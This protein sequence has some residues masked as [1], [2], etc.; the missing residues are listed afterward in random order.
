MFVQC[1]VWDSDTTSKIEGF[2][3]EILKDAHENDYLS[4]FLKE[5]I[6]TDLYKEEFDR[7][8]KKWNIKS[9]LSNEAE[10]ISVGKI[11]SNKSRE[12]PQ[13]IILIHPIIFS[14]DDWVDRINSL[15]LNVY[16]VGLLPVELQI[17]NEYYCN[18]PINHVADIFFAFFFETYY[19][20]LRVDYK[21]YSNGQPPISP[22]NIT[23]A[24]KRKLK[25]LQLKHQDDLKFD[26][27][28]IKAYDALFTFL[29]LSVEA[30]RYLFEFS[31]YGI[32]EIPMR[33]FI[34]QLHDQVINV[35]KNDP[36]STLFLKEVMID[37][38]G[39]SFL[40][41]IENPYEIKVS[42]DP[43]GLFPD[44]VDTHNRIVAFVDVLGF[45]NMIRR[46]DLEK[47]INLLKDLKE[48]L[49][50]A[51]LKMK[52]MFRTSSG[53]FECKL[54]SDC[55]CLSVP[56]YDT[57]TDFSYQFATVM[58]GIKTYQMLMLMKGYI[59]RGGIAIGSYYSNDNMI[60]S[61]AL[62]EAASFEKNGSTCGKSLPIKFPR[63]LVAPEILEKL[64]GTRIHILMEAYFKDG[65]VSDLDG[66]V[67]VN[68]F[69]NGDISRF[70]YSNIYDGFQSAEDEIA[71]TLKTIVKSSL[72]LIGSLL[73]PASSEIS[74]N[75]LI[76]E[77]NS[78]IL[79]YENESAVVSKYI[80]VS[81]F[82]DWLK[83]E[84]DPNRFKYYKVDF[85][86]IVDSW[87]AG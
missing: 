65:L 62:V 33:K 70:V 13:H 56:Y 6:I 67:F 59:L 51:V 75:V 47:D 85:K 50:G 78:K 43:K 3:V 41:I 83:K 48:S 73:T 52:A 9:V 44:V 53:N 22:R 7:I 87:N 27:L 31:E 86:E 11:C 15:L 49:D 55:F 36:Y 29:N 4:P 64:K 23:D 80:W 38:L 10:Y 12:D 19:A 69:F 42:E 25:R 34:T 17:A 32:F 26:Y 84:N 82:L 76:T 77:V 81:E 61:G 14:E 74:M 54:F 60:F 58:L 30:T 63:I 71:T 37:I 66:E 40:K 68:P 20:W 16:A 79:Q 72:E 57:D 24:Y 21:K 5:I 1:S 2:L 8:A 46:F 45:S 18:T 39:K 28:V 35:A